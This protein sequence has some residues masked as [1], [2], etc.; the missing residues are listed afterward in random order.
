VKQPSKIDRIDNK[1]HGIDEE[2]GLAGF[3]LA[4]APDWHTLVEMAVTTPTGRTPSHSEP[5]RARVLPLLNGLGMRRPQRRAAGYAVA[6]MGTVA[7]SLGL[8]A[9]RD[10]TTPL[11]KGFGFL[12]VVVAAAAAGGL[13]PASSPRSWGSWRSTSS[14]CLHTTPSSSPAPRTWWSCL[15]SS[16]CRS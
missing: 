14:S 3:T 5:T 12:V 4:A 6:T 15:C 1:I 13:G 8:L 2:I 9:F 7:L 11:S 16:G 10:D